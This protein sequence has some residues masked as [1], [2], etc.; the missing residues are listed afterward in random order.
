MRIS[1][2]GLFL[3]EPFP[4]FHSLDIRFDIRHVPA[5]LSQSLGMERGRTVAVGG[6][7]D[8]DIRRVVPV[9]A[10]MTGT[11]AVL[12]EVRD[13]V[14]LV[15]RSSESVDERLIHLPLQFL[16]T[17]L[18][19]PYPRTPEPP[20]QLR[21]FLNHQ[22]ISRQVFHIQR[23]GIVNILLPILYRLPRETEHQVDTDI[24]Y[25]VLAEQVN[26]LP[27]LMAVMPTVQEP[28]SLIREGLGPHAHPVNGQ[29]TNHLRIVGRDIIRVALHGDFRIGRHLIYLIYIMKQTMEQGRGKLR[30]RTAAEI[31]RVECG[32]WNVECGVWNVE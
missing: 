21:S 29:L 5:A 30:G 14:V 15:S 24:L 18:V 17:V 19:L 4:L 3:E 9:A 32:M 27:Y 1:I 12:G 23:K 7:T 28:Q 22:G 2:D 10:V 13:L 20:I 16:F 8:A 31:D 26:R 25:A 6:G 11:E